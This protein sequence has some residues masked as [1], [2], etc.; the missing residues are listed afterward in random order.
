[1][2]LLPALSRPDIPLQPARSLLSDIFADR[3]LTQLRSVGVNC[4]TNDNYAS[5]WANVFRELE[6]DG[7]GEWDA[8][9]APREPEH[10]RYALQRL[11]G[12]ALIVVDELDRLE[13]DEAL[14]LLADTIKTLS[15]HSVPVTLVL[16]GVADSVEDLIGD[17]QSVVRALTQIHIPRMQP[18]SWKRL[19]RR[20]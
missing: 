15:D 17:H 7:N 5:I 11:D 3:Q 1:M 10:V 2:R 14:S 13:D 9:D 6:W 16:V 19:S 12:G 20:D 8:R 4:H 18:K